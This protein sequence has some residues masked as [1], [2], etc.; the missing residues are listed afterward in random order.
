MTIAAAFADV[1][2]PTSKGSLIDLS[3]LW[4]KVAGSSHLG[5]HRRLKE[6][7]APED[8]TSPHDPA[9]HCNHLKKNRPFVGYVIPVSIHQP[10][11]VACRA[12]NQ[13]LQAKNIKC[14]G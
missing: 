9:E 3:A 10:I 5:D 6:R 13:L 7:L 8:K 14:S 4:L 2:P 12:M 1:N 11:F